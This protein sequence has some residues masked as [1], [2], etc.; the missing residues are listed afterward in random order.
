MMPAVGI[1]TDQLCNVGADRLKSVL[2]S[3]KSYLEQLGTSEKRGVSQPVLSHCRKLAKGL[4]A[5]ATI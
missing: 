2:V 1:Q 4:C 5:C 3:L